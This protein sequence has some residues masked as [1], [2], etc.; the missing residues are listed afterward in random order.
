MKRY[1]LSATNI[2]KVKDL[3]SD[4]W[5]KEADDS[6]VY[7]VLEVTFNQDATKDAEYIIHTD[8]GDLPRLGT[9]EFIKVDEPED[10]EEI[11]EEPKFSKK[12]VKYGNLSTIPAELLPLDCW[13]VK[14]YGNA[15]A[16]DS[17]FNKF[18]TPKMLVFLDES[19]A[20]AKCNTYSY[21]EAVLYMIDNNY[22]LLKA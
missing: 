18:G 12:S 4:I 7:K 9:D 16:T 3:P 5:V 19:A 20:Q 6:E 15:Y 17:K 13:L 8:K 10:V 11:V 14:G 22:S 21:A 2:Y 1:I